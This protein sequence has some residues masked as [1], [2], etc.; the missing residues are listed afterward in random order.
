MM[1]ILILFLFIHPISSLSYTVQMNDVDLNC[2]K[3]ATKLSSPH[4]E[5]LSFNIWSNELSIP[6]TL[7][8]LMSLNV[9][10][11]LS[12]DIE[13]SIK[14]QRKLGSSWINLP[15]LAGTSA[16]E[17]QSFCGLIQNACKNKSFIRPNI[18]DNKNSCSCD[19]DIGTYTIEH[20]LIHIKRKK[21]AKLTQSITPGQY[22]FH[23]MF[24]K[25][26]PYTTVGCVVSY[27]TLLKANKFT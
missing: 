23:V 25:T 18:K 15:C 1:F 19:L 10:K 3:E 13:F 21:S 26:K 14:V 4:I 5:I 27:L 7:D 20:F 2:R 8:F 12:N 16:C 22:R 6:G 9:T 11:K 24:L 17:K